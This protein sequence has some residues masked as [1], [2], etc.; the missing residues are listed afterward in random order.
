MIASHRFR[1]EGRDPVLLPS[2]GVWL[3]VLLACA[4]GC[5]A[6]SEQNSSLVCSYSY[7]GTTRELTALPSAE[8]YTVT[9]TDVQHRFA[10]KVVYQLRPLTI[11]VYVYERAEPKD[12]LLQELKYTTP[13]PAARS[14]AAFG[15]TGQ[16]LV[17]SSEGRELQY[18]C[19]LRQPR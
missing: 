6:G 18:H 14:D 19:A 15:F 3:G 7:G 1:S 11:N 8:P 4:G 12:V 10:F 5:R 13:F 17:Y 2:L 16:Q 9:S